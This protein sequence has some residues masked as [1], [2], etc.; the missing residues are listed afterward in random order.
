MELTEEWKQKRQ[1]GR[2]QSYEKES[3]Q[4]E[5]LTKKMNEQPMEEMKQIEI[6]KEL[7]KTNQKENDVSIHKKYIWIFK[8]M[9][10][11]FFR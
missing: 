7:E 4:L 9:E 3:K 5:E 11:V 6:Q 2:V 10:F 8:S 1:K